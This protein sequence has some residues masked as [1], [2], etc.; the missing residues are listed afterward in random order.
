[1]SQNTIT[2]TRESKTSQSVALPLPYYAM[3]KTSYSEEFFA[4]TGEKKNMHVVLYQPDH[5]C[6]F[7][8]A[9]KDM[10][11][12]AEQVSESV[13]IHGYELAQKAI[14]ERFLTA[15][16]NASADVATLQEA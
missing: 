12:D 13:F 11:E 8:V 6:V 16:P 7:T 2:I 9:A 15:C 1:M 10:P 3:H 4:I 14:T 5:A